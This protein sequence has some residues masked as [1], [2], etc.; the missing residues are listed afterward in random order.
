METIARDAKYEKIIARNREKHL[1]ETMRA[2]NGQMMTIIAYDGYENITVRFED[3]TIVPERKYVYFKKGAIANPNCRRSESQIRKL[4][5]SRIRKLQEKRIGETSVATNGMTLKIT[6][7][8]NYNDIDVV[9]VEDGYSVTGTSYDLFQTGQIRNPKLCAQNGRSKHLH[10]KFITNEG[11][12]IE[13]IDW[14]K[15][16]DVTVQ[17]KDGSTKHTDYKSI[18]NGNVAKPGNRIS[19]DDIKTRINET[20]LAGCGQVMTIIAARSSTDIDIRFENGDIV[21]HAKYNDFKTGR[22]RIPNR[23]INKIEYSLR[24][25][26]FGNIPH[27]KCK[28]QLCGFEDYMTIEQMKQHNC[29]ITTDFIADIVDK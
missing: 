2:N 20:S 19:I 5:T 6:A 15:Y 12:E 23:V 9:F 14:K 11:E 7:Y 28:C 18:Q 21:Q 16:A 27:W 26:L 1:N 17:F 24:K 10:E 4:A 25:T 13:I 8:R 29:Q 3:G 22:I